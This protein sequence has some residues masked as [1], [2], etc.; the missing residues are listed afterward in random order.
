MPVIAAPTEA[1]TMAASEIGV[2]ITRSW[3]N[4]SD[5]PSV[6][7]KPPPKPPGTPRS[8]PS[9]KTE[10]SARIATRSASRSASVMPMRRGPV[11]SAAGESGIIRVTATPSVGEN[12][13][14]AVS[15]QRLGA[16][17]GEGDR[18]LDLRLAGAL[19]RFQLALALLELVEEPL[20]EQVH[21]V[22][23]TPLL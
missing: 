16:R 13:G 18:L 14:E 22:A 1:P 6:T 12:V 11:D 2:S 10:G 3:P 19:D 4:S 20:A 7:V 17:H 5:S 9:R 15:G 23:L 8:S 21:R